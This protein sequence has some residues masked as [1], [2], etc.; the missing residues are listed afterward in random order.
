M[1]KA[2]PSEVMYSL[3]MVQSGTVTVRRGA[4]QD[5]Y[6]K[7]GCSRVLLRQ[8]LAGQGKETYWLSKV[9]CREDLLRQVLARRSAETIC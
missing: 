8:V 1:V 5:G 6:G 4:A 2:T 7:A 9:G 3:G